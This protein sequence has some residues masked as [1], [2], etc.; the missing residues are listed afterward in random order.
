MEQWEYIARIF[1]A[2]IKNEGAKEYLQENY[3]DWKNPPKYWVATLDPLLN[4]L[5]NQG[6]ELV[7]MEPVPGVGSNGDVY[8][9][10]NIYTYSNAYFCVFKRRKATSN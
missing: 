7:H 9:H 3:P 10:G 2:D 4:S 6:W 8:Y 5:G 1:F